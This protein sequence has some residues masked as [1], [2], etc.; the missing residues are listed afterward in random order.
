MPTITV[1]ERWKSE[2]ERQLLKALVLL[3]STES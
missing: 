3:R 2:A 1:R